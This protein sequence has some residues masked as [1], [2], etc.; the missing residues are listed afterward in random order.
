MVQ[1]P[2]TLEEVAA[3]AGVSRSTASRALMG[4]ASPK[5]RSRVEAAARELGYAPN[6]VARAL[7]GGSGLRLVLAV[8]GRS[9][10]QLDDPYTHRV[11]GAIAR[12]AAPH[13][14]GVSA[15]WLPMDRAGRDLLDRLG[16]DR[17][18]SGVV[19]LNTTEHVLAAL[20]STLR[21]RVASIG[22]GAPGVPSFD[23]DNGGGATNVLR[24]M[25]GSGRRRIAMIT[26]PAW[27]PCARRPVAAYRDFMAATAA[28]VRLV[29]GDF[30]AGSGRVAAIEILQ[31]W[32]D[33]DAVYAI[34][35]TPALGAMH[36]LRG[37]GVDVPG[38]VAVAGFDDI[39]FAE[40]SA[41]ALTTA[42]HPVDS[43]A[44]AAA[45]ALLAGGP[46]PPTTWFA[47]T[48]IARRSA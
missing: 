1:H 35:D 45:M 9:A 21:G 43:I 42:S 29:D 36:A 47:S 5:A 7:A 11:V 44:S 39:P 32:P 13:G 31:R 2:P 33:T 37:R 46:I 28:P 24:H 4:R 6:L 30:S 41:P 10:D 22:V 17:G 16:E 19:L 40:L 12:T 20:P 8:H 23:V 25:Y 14:V 34:S 27:L 48:L 38:D 18:V 26:G 3:V 15:H